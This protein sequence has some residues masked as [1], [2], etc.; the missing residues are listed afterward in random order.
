[1]VQVMIAPRPN[2]NNWVIRRSLISIS[3]PRRLA[4]R[5]DW[6]YPQTDGTSVT[7]VT[8]WS[9]KGNCPPAR[10][11]AAHAAAREAAM[12]A[13]AQPWRRK[14]LA[15]GVIPNCHMRGRLAGSAPHSDR[16]TAPARAGRHFA[17][18]ERHRA[19]DRG[20]P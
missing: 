5:W 8:F 14:G 6:L 4:I 16:I 15:A 3:Q 7:P 20:F 19:G 12:A 1:M 13:F 10:L 11:T 2:P 9:N 18:A 17:V